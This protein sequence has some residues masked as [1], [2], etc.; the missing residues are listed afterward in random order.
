MQTY[1]NERLS[2][3][4][5]GKWANRIVCFAKWVFLCGSL[6]A[7]V[8]YC[9][10]SLDLHLSTIVSNYHYHLYDT[11]IPID[12]LLRLLFSF[13]FLVHPPREAAHAG[14]C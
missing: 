3:R 12:I 2:G 8:L 5:P 7:E 13:L 14:V 9:S 4:W 10:K 11:I 6:L 1:L